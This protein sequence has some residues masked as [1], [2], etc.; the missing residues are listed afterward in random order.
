MIS[1]NKIWKGKKLLGLSLFL[2]F[3]LL[4]YLTVTCEEREVTLIADIPYSFVEEKKIEAAITHI[5]SDFIVHL[6]DITAQHPPNV[7]C[8]ETLYSNMSQLLR[9]SKVP[10]FIIP[11]D[12]EWTDCVNDKQAWE[13]WTQYFLMFDLKF[14]H[15]YKVTRQRNREENF[16]FTYQGNIFI[17]VN[18]VNPINKSRFQQALNWC[19]E[20]LAEAADDVFLAIILAHPLN[21]RF[22]IGLTEEIKNFARPV[23][24]IHGDQHRFKHTVKYKDISNLDLLGL[25][26]GEDENFITKLILSNFFWG[27]PY[28][29]ERW[30]KNFTPP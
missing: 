16:A 3:P 29:I 27:K 4:L 17:G 6:G 14:S 7:L 18:L 15:D 30:G 19:R 12:N 21:N 5:K 8:E 28:T 9:Q 24:Y 11:G 22:I 1:M 10:V 25:P 26:S 13:F 2:A 23:L 20:K